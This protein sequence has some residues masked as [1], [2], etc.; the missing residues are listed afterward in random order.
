MIVTLIGATLL[1]FTNGLTAPLIEKVE[2]E[3]KTKARREVINADKFIPIDDSER[4]FRAISDDGELIGYVILA[5]AEGG[6]A[7]SFK[8]MV[9]VDTN[10]RIV[11]LKILTHKE[12]P[13]LGTKI[14]EPWFLSQYEGKTT[15]NLIVVKGMTS[16]K[17]QAI[18][19][20]T[21]SSKAVTNGV[22]KGIE[23]LKSILRQS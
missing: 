15:K 9:G 8:V 1:A 5:I 11:R 14:E 22:R 20:A 6:Y 23:E 4:F 17:I 10:F 2:E 13:G 16:D 18:S 12:T 3:A 21:I 19:G 7:G